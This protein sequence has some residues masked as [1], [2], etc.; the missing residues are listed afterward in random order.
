MKKDFI[1]PEAF[2]CFSDFV[3]TFTISLFLVHFDAKCPIKL[4]TDASGYSISEILSQKQRTEW[5]VVAYFSCKM[6]DAKK[7]HEIYDAELLAIIKNFC[8]WHHY[9][10]QPYHTMEVF[11]DHGNLP[12][13][14]NTPK[15]TRRQVRWVFDLFTFDFLLDYRKGTLNPA[16]GLLCRPD[17]QRDVGLKDSMTGNTS[18]FQKMLFPT[19]AG[20]TSQPMSPT[21][22]K[23][24]Q[25]RVVDTSDLGSSNQKR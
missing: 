24:K 3:A 2:R 25:I 9:L 1:M 6:I 14:M 23:P 19:V 22:Q 5:K 18:A 21:E 11:T 16:D 10:E 12:A 4:E 17:Y 7:N 13:F 20:V 8:H 15:L